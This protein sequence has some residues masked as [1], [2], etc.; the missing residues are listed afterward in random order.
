[1]ASLDRRGLETLYRTELAYMVRLAH[2]ITGSNAVAEELVHDAFI[3]LHK[4]WNGI[5][6]PRAY[7]KR[8]V[9]NKSRSHLRRRDVERRHAPSPQPPVLPPEMDDTWHRLAALS[10]KRRTAVVLRYYADLPIDEI[11]TLMSVRPGTV[12]SLLHRG[13]KDLKEQLT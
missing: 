13:L 9:V 3:E 7:L 8:S 1:M 12:K 4:R 10:P 6:D 11:A 2:V 5:R